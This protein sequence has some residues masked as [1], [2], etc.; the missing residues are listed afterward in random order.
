MSQVKKFRL[1]TPEEKAVLQKFVD[2]PKFSHHKDEI[3]KFCKKYKRTYQSVSQYI[4][5]TRRRSPNKTLANTTISVK[6][7]NSKITSPTLRR[8]EFVIPVNNWELQTSEEGV[9]LVLKF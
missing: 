6:K 2:A 5:N 7:N 9:M 3:D 1:Y 4:S 8:N